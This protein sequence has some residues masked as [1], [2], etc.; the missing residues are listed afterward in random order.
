MSD[1]VKTL[2]AINNSLIR[3][4]ER[5]RIRT[6]LNLFMCILFPYSEEDY[7]NSEVGYPFMPTNWFHCLEMRGRMDAL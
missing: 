1:E 4:T 5:K 3:A 2:C 7:K 6:S